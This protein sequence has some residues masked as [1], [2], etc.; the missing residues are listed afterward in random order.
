MAR[1]QKRAG[2][3]DSFDYGPPRKNGRKEKALAAAAADAAA[4]SSSAQIPDVVDE[5]D[6]NDD[7]DSDESDHGQDLDIL[8]SPP[9]SSNP[10]A[11][12]VAAS[13]SS[14]QK[15]ST[16]ETSTASVDPDIGVGLRGPQSDSDLSLPSTF[17]SATSEFPD[18]VLSRI[19]QSSIVAAL[20]DA[21]TSVEVE[22]RAHSPPLA[23]SGISNS[24]QSETRR[25]KVSDKA[26]QQLTSLVK[27]AE[28]QSGTPKTASTPS[29][30]SSTAALVDSGDTKVLEAS[31]G[32]WS[33]VFD[34]RSD[35][36]FLFLL[37]K[38]LGQVKCK[39]CQR[40]LS[41]V[42]AS[43]TAMNTHALNCPKSSSRA[44]FFS[45]FLVFFCFSYCLHRCFDSRVV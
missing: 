8:T 12:D 44:I 37:N 39:A 4:K 42:K 22:R 10:A 6:A 18:H 20:P 17:A 28:G 7:D 27:P 33:N 24:S 5:A 13:S 36:W 25:T 31:S 30:S 35:C 1:V 2:K 23:K 38:T 45:C 15:T 11:L 14:D 34:K 29:S 40:V 32:T 9:V 21:A 16:A 26:I 43:T 3:F 19:V 41:F